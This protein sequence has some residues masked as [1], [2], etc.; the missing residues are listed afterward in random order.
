METLELKQPLLIDDQ[1]ITSIQ[2]DTAKGTA[3]HFM[4]AHK[5]RNIGGSEFILPVNDT[6]FMFE[7]GVEILLCCNADK[8]WSR[9][10]FNRVSGGD[11]LQI[12]TIGMVFFTGTQGEQQQDNSEPQ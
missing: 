7:L 8:G 2:Y 11:I 5:R 3:T 1:K 9:E 4:N 10:D 12:S 6:A